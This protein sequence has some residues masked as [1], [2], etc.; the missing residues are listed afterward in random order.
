MVNWTSCN[1]TVMRNFPSS[2]SQSAFQAARKDLGDVV[3]QAQKEISRLTSDEPDAQPTASTVPS[4]VTPPPKKQDQPD[5]DSDEVEEKD[6]VESFNES[7]AEATLAEPPTASTSDSNSDTFVSHARTASQS[8]FSRF[9]ATLP[10]NLVSTVQQQLPESLKHAPNSIDFGN[11]RNTLTSEFQRVQGI[12][13]AQAEEYVHRSEGLLREAGE[14]LKDAVKVVPPEEGSSGTFAP[15]G[16][17]WD[18]TDIWMLPDVGTTPTGKG[19]ERASSSSRGPSA[20]G[21]RAVATRAESLLKQL[22]HDPEV[23]RV[24]PE[25]DLRA[26]ELYDVWIR[27]VLNS[28]EGGI[29]GEEWNTAFQKALDDPVDGQG[30]K[31]TRDTL[32]ESFR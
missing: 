5:I 2:K 26:K 18:G 9:Q 11:L 10:P 6:I 25:V 31:S 22:R 28:K 27:D 29:S 32:G 16:T 20:D 19:K 30:L 7:E 24:D 8:L 12:T 17:L 1:S 15:A 21:L 14:F 3:S 23:I 13:R 4:E